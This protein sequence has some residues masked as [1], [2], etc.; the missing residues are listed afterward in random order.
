MSTGDLSAE[1]ATRVHLAACFRLLAR[2]GFSDLAGGHVSARI[3]GTDDF[4]LNPYGYLFEDVT[5]SSLIRVGM[6]GIVADGR[7][8]R[9]NKA[10]FLLHSTI[11]KSRPDVQAAG[12]CH[13]WAITAVSA[14]ESGLLPVDQ[15]AIGFWKDLAYSDYN[16]LETE[17]ELARMMADLGGANTI[18]LRNHG[19]VALGGAIPEVWYRIYKLNMA[20]EI[21]LRAQSAAAGKPL[22]LPPSAVL[23]DAASRWETP[24]YAAKGWEALTR[25]LDAEDSA[26]KL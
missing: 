12:H 15:A 24:V 3:P 23:D 1:Q 9:L 8:E 6:N 19:L 7:Q 10:A 17:E 13:T 21:Q 25:R 2:F 16:F 14:L 4:L 20:C 26:Y 22:V 5:A 11:L 18:I